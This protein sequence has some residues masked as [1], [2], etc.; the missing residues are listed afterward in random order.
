V[1][2][3]GPPAEGSEEATLPR[4]AAHAD[5]GLL[6]LDALALFRDGHTEGGMRCIR[7]LQRSPKLHDLV[8][9]LCPGL[10]LQHDRRAQRI[11]RTILGPDAGRGIGFAGIAPIPATTTAADLPLQSHP[12]TPRQRALLALL[13]DGLTNR[14]IAER[15]LISENTVKW[16]L[17]AL[18]RR[19]GAGNRC[20]IICIAER[21]SLIPPRFV[22]ERGETRLHFAPA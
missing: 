16:H 8:N 1:L 18:S 19:L 7:K 11:R 20:S 13:R 17:K 10:A 14:Q 3:A 5:E 22:T 21:K 4:G 2:E 12:L 9:Q 6:L 15:M